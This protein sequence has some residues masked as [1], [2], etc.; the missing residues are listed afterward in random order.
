MPINGLML[1][2]RKHHLTPHLLDLR[3]SGDTA[4]PR[5]QVVSYGAFVFTLPYSSL[6]NTDYAA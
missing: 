4:G 2:A 6:G 3:N 5:E 1:A